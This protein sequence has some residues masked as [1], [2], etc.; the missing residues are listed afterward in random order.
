MQNA[1]ILKRHADLVDRMADRVGLDLEDVMME[2]RM[3][4]EDIND[5]VL[6]CTGCANPAECEHWLAGPAEGSGAVPDYCR[7]G[8]LFSRL[9]DGGRA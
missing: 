2:G 6:A 5:A 3:L 4:P 7:N 8:Q 1:H 9:K